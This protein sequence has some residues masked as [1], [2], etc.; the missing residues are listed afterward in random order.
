MKQTEAIGKTALLEIANEMMA[1]HAHYF[2]GMA[3][4]DVE[5]RGDVLVFRG[6]CFLDEHGL[7]GDKSTV[8]FNVL[9]YLATELSPRYQLEN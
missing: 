2:Y 1:Q 6:N 3:V 8:V 9:K 7:P 5:Q 4:S